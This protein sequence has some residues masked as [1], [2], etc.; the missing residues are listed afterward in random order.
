MSLKQSKAKEFLC[1]AAIFL[2]GFI[3]MHDMALMPIYNEL[4]KVFPDSTFGVNLIV[5]FTMAITMVG[6]LLAPFLLKKM[7]KKKLLIIT[8]VLFAL[9]SIFGAAVVNIVYMNV[10][11]VINALCQGITMVC[12]AGLLTDIFIDDEVKRGKIMGLYQGS[13]SIFGAVMSALAGVLALKGWSHVYNIY[14]FSIIITVFMVLFVPNGI[15]SSDEVK[16]EELPENAQKAHFS[17]SFWMTG[18]IFVLAYFMYV[19]CIQFTSVYIETNAIGDA[20][21]A[22]LMVSISSVACFL[23][24][25]ALGFFIDKFHRNTLRIMIVVGIIGSLAMYFMQNQIGCILG[26]V[27]VGGS[28][29]VISAYSFVEMPSM[30]PAGKVDMSLSL[31]SVFLTVATFV[32][33]NI[34][35]AI[36]LKSSINNAI[37]LGAGIAVVAFVLE[38]IVGNKLKNNSA[39]QA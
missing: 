7:S 8:T 19:F 11:N 17:S 2:C 14:W 39:P 36:M 6:S 3:I 34:A 38:L 25:I 10:L 9:S 23:C 5:S 26:T 29:A 35:S 22:G 12:G 20:S 24:Q 1:I 32:G 13:M 16:A 4:Y 30:A 18:L 27:L 28:Y 21:F 15:K 31:C 37:I 33:A